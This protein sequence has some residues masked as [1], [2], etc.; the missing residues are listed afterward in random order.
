MQQSCNMKAEEILVQHN[1]KKTITRLKVL[2]VYIDRPYAL[3]HSDVEE[4]LGSD[5]D[6]VTLYRTL[7]TLEDN[8]ILHKVFDEHG[9]VKYSLCTHTCNDH[10]HIDQHLH[11]HC[12]SCQKTICLEQTE[13]PQLSLPNQF[14]VDDFYMM[15]NGICNDCNA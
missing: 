4:T 13:I 6:R 14:Q 11:F 1:L 10:K 3:S 9:K 5:F 8:G 12:R 7:S 2:K 15:A